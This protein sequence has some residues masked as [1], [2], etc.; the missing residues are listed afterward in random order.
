MRIWEC[1][2]P[3]SLPDN[4]VA[5]RFNDITTDEDGLFS[6]DYSGIW[7]VLT[8]RTVNSWAPH[9]FPFLYE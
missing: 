6:L 4:Q 2:S 1:V 9:G 8:G 3:E 5:Q 7:A